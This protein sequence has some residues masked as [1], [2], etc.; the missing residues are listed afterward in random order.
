[1][2]TS[3]SAMLILLVKS[4]GLWGFNGASSSSNCGRHC[5][6]RVVR[7]GVVEEFCGPAT[8]NPAPGST[9]QT[10]FSQ[11]SNFESNAS[12]AASGILK[13]TKQQLKTEH[14]MAGS[15]VISSLVLNFRSNECCGHGDSLTK[16]RDLICVPSKAKT[17]SDGSCSWKAV[18][19]AGLL[20]GPASSQVSQN[21][22]PRGTT[23]Y[24]V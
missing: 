12:C 9:A 1:M 22:L 13:G 11:Y 17:F 2:W 5:V 15:K 14:V 3:K 4:T 19:D 6:R 21:S 18:S 7:V 20:F 10:S 8:D 23:S 16:P 24:Q